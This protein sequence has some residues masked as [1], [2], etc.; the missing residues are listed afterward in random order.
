M[1]RPDPASFLNTTAGA[2]GRLRSLVRPRRICG[3]LS[4]GFLATMLSLTIK[5]KN[6]FKA[7]R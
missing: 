3:S 4:A 2:T 1:W 5:A 7:L 6:N